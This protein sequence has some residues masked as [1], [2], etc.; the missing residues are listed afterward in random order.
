METFQLRKKKLPTTA[1]LEL[2]ELANDNI[3]TVLDDLEVEYNTPYGFNNEIRTSCP[4]HD[5]DNKTSFSYNKEYKRW[6]CYTNKCHDQRSDIFGLVSAIKG[7]NNDSWT[8]RDSVRYLSNLLGF[9]VSEETVEESKETTILRSLIRKNYTV[10]QSK[11]EFPIDISV[12]KSKNNTSPYFISKGFSNEVIKKFHIGECY[13]RTKPMYYRAYVPIIDE[14][15]KQVLGVTGRTLFPECKKCE[16]YHDPKRNCP[17]EDEY[18]KVQSKWLHYGFNK[19]AVLYNLN[20]AKE[21]IQK[22]GVAILTEG[23]KEV[24]WLYQ[25]GIY[26]AVSI[27]GVDLSKHQVKSLLK[28]GCVKVILGLD[29]DDSGNEASNKIVEEYGHVFKFYKIQDFLK[30][31]EDLDDI[32]EEKIPTLKQIIKLIEEKYA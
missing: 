27:L 22:T 9:A 2:K 19:M 14:S 18:T 17:T 21:Y 23:P 3:E 26:N 24:W 11:K 5:G 1:I 10:S 16:Y 28:N 12:L 4:V 6:A 25:Q 20:I 29:N 8:F 32:S 30:D 15:G 31:Y 13:D 7:K